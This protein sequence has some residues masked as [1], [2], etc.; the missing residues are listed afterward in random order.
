M[1]NNAEL[2]C[3]PF[4]T[5]KQ[6]LSDQTSRP[7]SALGLLQNWCIKQICT[8][9]CIFH[10]M[11]DICWL[12]GATLCHTKSKVIKLDWRAASVHQQQRQQQQSVVAVKLMLWSNVMSCALRLL[13]AVILCPMLL[14]LKLDLL[15]RATTWSKASSA[16]LSSCYQ[17]LWTWHC[18][19]PRCYIEYSLSLY[20]GLLGNLAVQD[21][22][23]L[24]LWV[25]YSGCL[26]H[27]MKEGSPIYNCITN[28]TAYTTKI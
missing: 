4:M 18:L 27:H 12:Y 16:Q 13:V 5:I 26:N 3:T 1:Q 17:M 6:Q 25:L 11:A 28:Q 8:I 22:H 7:Q 19:V 9:F 2:T 20:T 14:N 10:L 21:L 24:C 23:S 15:N